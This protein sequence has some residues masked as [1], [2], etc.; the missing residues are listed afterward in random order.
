MSS[1]TIELRRRGNTTNLSDAVYADSKQ[2]LSSCWTSNGDVYTGLSAEQKKAFMPDILAIPAD[3]FQ[4]NREVKAWFTNISIDIPAVGIILEAGLDSDKKPLSPLDYVKYLFAISHPQVAVD[5]EDIKRKY[6]YR[7]YVFDSQRIKTATFASLELRKKAYKE[8][9]KLDTG[10]KKIGMMLRLYGQ[11]PDKMDAQSQTIYLED[12]ANTDSVDF[13]DK[14]TDKNLEL[15][16]FVEECISAKVL[17]K[18]GNNYYEGD[19]KLGD[20]L[21]DTM[22]YLKDAKNSTAL[23]RIKALLQQYYKS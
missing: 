9:I 21:A 7:F 6:K 3:D 19:E 16:A 4:F 22:L 23:V 5:E 11:N 2:K 14:I 15:N 10:D 12:K 8:F 1:K 18:V 20:D 17:R 13:Y